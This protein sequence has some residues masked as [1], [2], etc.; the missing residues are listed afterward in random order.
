MN[1]LFSSFCWYAFVCLPIMQGLT[2]WRYI[3]GPL[4]RNV[5][6]FQVFFMNIVKWQSLLLFDAILLSRYILIVWLKNPA[7][8][9]DD[10]WSVYINFLSGCIAVLFNF[11]IFF[12]SKRLSLIFYTCSN[13]DPTADYQMPHSEGY[14]DIFS[15]TLYLVVKLR[16]TFY[17]RFQNSVNS[18]TPSFSL[19][20][21]ETQTI[22]DLTSLIVSKLAFALLA[23]LS[24]KVNKL[25]LEEVNSFPHYLSVYA[26]QLLGPPL[27]CIVV[28]GLQFIR[29]KSIRKCI[30]NQCRETIACLE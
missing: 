8:V 30:S 15:I 7:A 23:L 14:I 24:S 11:V 18:F 28:I 10:F 27:I 2:S 20:A 6:F 22:I 26:F 3:V 5:C 13:T 16:L 21:I 29:R 1:K 12:F 9:N 19:N 25:S 17:K 4:H